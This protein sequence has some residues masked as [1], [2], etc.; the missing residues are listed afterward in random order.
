MFRVGALSSVLPS[1][2]NQ[3]T[4]AQELSAHMRALRGYRWAVSGYH[5]RGPGF[6]LSAASFGDG[7]LLADGARNHNGSSDL[8][9][10][11]EA[12]RLK[13]ATPD[14]AAMLDPG[15]Y[16]TEIVHLDLSRPLGPVRSKHDILRSPQCSLTPKQGFRRVS[17]LEFLPL[18]HAAAASSPPAGASAPPPAGPPSA[19]RELEMGEV[20]PECGGEVKERPLFTGSYV[21]CL[22]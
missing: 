6:W 2:M 12:F 13:V 5:A 1:G 7:L 10:L 15:F 11:I 20:C 14:D 19:R 17:V 9:L 8:D 18:I 4:L 21:G 22:C 16:A 3:Y